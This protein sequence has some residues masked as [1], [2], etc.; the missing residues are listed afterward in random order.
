MIQIYHIDWKIILI[1]Y[2]HWA[3]FNKMFHITIIQLWVVLNL[4]YQG[5]RSIPD[6]LT[7]L[8]YVKAY[9]NKIKTTAN[10]S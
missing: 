6:T 7:T 9:T 1:I 4:L 2:I 3:S 5:Y 8:N 10:Y